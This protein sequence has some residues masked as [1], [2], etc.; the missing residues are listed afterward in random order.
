M[1][2]RGIKL[3]I[4]K[5]HPGKAIEFGGLI[6]NYYNGHDST[7]RKCGGKP[8]RPNRPMFKEGLWGSV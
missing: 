8:P 6:Q 4:G 1:G 3:S 5:K 7:R 2:Y